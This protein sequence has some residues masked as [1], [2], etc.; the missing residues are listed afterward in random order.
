MHKKETDYKKA[1]INKIQH[2]EKEELLYR[3]YY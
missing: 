1:V 3:K 2:N